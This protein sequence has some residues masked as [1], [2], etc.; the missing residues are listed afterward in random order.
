MKLAGEKVR[1][2]VGIEGGETRDGALL[3]FVRVKDIAY[4][5]RYEYEATRAIIADLFDGRL[6]E[7]SLDNVRYG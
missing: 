5:E 3:G 7:V 4:P 1:F 6:H 2:F